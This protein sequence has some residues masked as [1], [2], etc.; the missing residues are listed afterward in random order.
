[1]R[2]VHAPIAR[3]SR[4]RPSCRARREL[5]ERRLCRRRR[6]ARRSASRRAT[7]R[8]ARSSVTL[9]ALAGEHR[10][11]ALGAARTPRRAGPAAR[12]SPRSAGASSSR[13]T[14]PPP[15]AASAFA[16][17]RVLGE[18]LA[19]V[20]AADLGV[21]PFAVRPGARTS[22]VGIVSPILRRPTSS[23]FVHASSRSPRPV[24]RRTTG[25]RRSCSFT[26][27]D[28][29]RSTPAFSKALA[30]AHRRGVSAIAG[31]TGLRRSPSS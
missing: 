11:D 25:R 9:I 26:S 2:P 16:A 3:A 10:V 14:V 7:C 12:A 28:A 20:A 4:S 8:T 27:T 6:C 24:R 19:Q 5:R 15:S 29:A 18:D 22:G 1:M 13:G 31:L 23:L 30:R 21:V 17:T